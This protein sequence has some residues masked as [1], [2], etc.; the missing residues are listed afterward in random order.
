MTLRLLACFCLLMFTRMI[1]SQEEI[2]GK[3]YP[4]ITP[5]TMIVL[6]NG[7]I[8]VS[9][10]TSDI[11]SFAIDKFIL[12]HLN[13]EGEVLSKTYS[14]PNERNSSRPGG[15]AGWG[16]NGFCYVQP[17]FMQ[18]PFGN[19]SYNTNF[20]DASGNQVRS[21]R[22]KLNEP[23]FSFF[24]NKKVVN[25][26]D[27]GV[28]ITG[29]TRQIPDGTGTNSFA[30]LIRFDE[31]GNL[32]F[33]K[34]FSHA[35][36]D[37]PST[38]GVL[39]APS[40]DL[41]LL[42]STRRSNPDATNIYMTRIDAAGD[43]IWSKRFD[44]PD[45]SL[46]TRFSSGSFLR[47]IV[48]DEAG[49]VNFR[50]YLADGGLG[51]VRITP[52]GDYISAT[53][54]N[55]PPSVNFRGAVELLNGP[56]GD[57]IAVQHSRVSRE[58]L[59]GP[60]IK[61]N[62][63][64]DG[65]PHSAAY[66]IDQDF[67]LQSIK[68]RADGGYYALGVR[69]QTGCSASQSRSSTLMF[70]DD[71]MRSDTLCYPNRPLSVSRTNLPDFNV[72]NLGTMKPLAINELPGETMTAGTQEVFDLA[73]TYFDADA[74]EPLTLQC[75]VERLNIRFMENARVSTDGS[76]ILALSIRLTD[77][78][79]RG[80]LFLSAG[81]P[82]EVTGNNTR[83]I[84]IKTGYALDQEAINE[85]ILAVTYRAPDFAV[86][87]GDHPYQLFHE[88]LCGEVQGRQDTF[89]VVSPPIFPGEDQDVDTVLCFPNTLTLAVDGPLD[90]QF[91]WSTGDSSRMLLVS[92]AGDY[93]VT[94]SNFCGADSAF[95][96]V[97]ANE[98]PPLEDRA[99]EYDLCPGDTIRFV[100]TVE[101][102]TRYQW[103]DGSSGGMRNFTT[104]GDYLLMRTNACSEAVTSI[105]I[106]LLPSAPVLEDR[107]ER[108]LCEAATITLAVPFIRETDYAWSTGA[109]DTSLLIST[110]GDYSV[111]V[112]NVCGEG[113]SLFSVRASEDLPLKD[114]T[115]S[116]SFCL[117]D[118]IVFTVP[119]DATRSYRWE[120]DSLTGPERWFKTSGNYVLERSNACFSAE[121][122]V[123]VAA[124]SCCSVYL[125]TAFSPNGDGVNDVFRPFPNT[126]YCELTGNETLDIY[127]RWGGEV[128]RGGTAGWN[129]KLKNNKPCAAGT[130]V[131]VFTYQDAGATVRRSDSVVLIR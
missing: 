50:I 3:I 1:G 26:A 127:D 104:G 98:A 53:N 11:V 28:L 87:D 93:A 119:T 34:R 121:T 46:R 86:L 14:E 63:A 97:T 74:V 32:V 84:R 83:S 76:T 80:T 47:G 107:V 103:E 117:T 68:E 56:N 39:E 90:A 43:L 31:Q 42:T 36:G 9:G 62:I 71:A 27:G 123:R 30:G 72:L 35:N 67:F 19:I 131:Y 38:E 17:S 106:N 16:N 73:C 37:G 124:T 24:G 116:F 96:R 118:S 122:V 66:I 48:F 61:F 49:N 110:P 100:P 20:H 25:L 77:S 60:A 70:L 13:S 99:F 82:V 113:S 29:D 8:V 126:R 130:Y 111:M 64:P 2:P 22:L 115:I 109:T 108:V 101:M 79:D 78:L 15:L 94:V 89:I 58:A 59:I 112:S 51:I 33:S 45:S 102:G 81:F 10:Y 6:D 128:F 92:Q 91:S 40:G 5:H 18:E 41:L 114:T 69:E 23:L 4:D 57:L 75:D 129:G 12:L 85:I 105:R 44:A 55:L 88:Y 120:D 54:Y 95:F 52:D 125:P 7:N 21:L 65:A